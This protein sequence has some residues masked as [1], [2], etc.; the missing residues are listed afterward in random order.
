MVEYISLSGLCLLMNGG[1][2]WSLSWSVHASSWLAGCRTATPVQLGYFVA[3]EDNQS[4]PHVVW[5]LHLNESNNVHRY[6]MLP[7]SPHSNLTR[8]LVA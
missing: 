1:Q 5:P 3:A 2:E 4:K 8:V 6:S 7:A